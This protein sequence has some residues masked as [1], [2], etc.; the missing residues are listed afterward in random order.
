MPIPLNHTGAGVVTITAPASGTYSLVLPTTAG[1]SGQFLQTDGTGTTTW[2]NSLSTSGNY[3]INSLGVGVAASGTAGDIKAATLNI[4]KGSAGNLAY[5]TDGVNADFYIKT[6]SLVTTIGPN[7][8]STTMVFQTSGAERARIDSSGNF[9]IGTT[10]PSAKL[11]VNGANVWIRAKASSG[12]YALIDADAAASQQA[13]FRFLANGVE[14]ARII[15]PANTNA[16]TLVFCNGAAA[17]EW[18]RLT[19]AG[20]LGINTSSPIRQLTLNGEFSITPSGT[21][22]F[23]NVSDSAGSNG[24]TKSLNIRGLGTSGTAEVNLSAITLTT[25]LLICTGVY[26][27]AVGATNRDVYV[28]NA[29]NIGYVASIRAAK[30]NIQDLT[31]TSWLYQLNPVSF[32]YRKKDADGN[33]TDETDGDVQYGMIAEDVAQVRPDLCFY[34]D[35]DGKQ[36]LRGVQYSKLLPV[37][38]KALK[39]QQ[40]IIDSLTARVAALEAAAIMSQPSKDTP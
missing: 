23:I 8:G 38:L 15:S 13:I 3:Q 4:N 14:Q 12:G 31:D 1:S 33:Y 17:T 32:N 20:Y 7:A 37:M 9:G 21:Q 34:D 29:G 16:D 6:T 26:G 28:D 39:D 30:T 10:S 40:A 24:T 36:E 11:D 19:A 25:S 18:M 5:F 2:A 27:T 22:A 35:V